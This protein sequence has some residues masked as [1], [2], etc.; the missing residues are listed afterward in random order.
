LPAAERSFACWWKVFCVLA[1][2]WYPPGIVLIHAESLGESAGEGGRE[3]VTLQER[4]R[5]SLVRSGR[6]EYPARPRWIFGAPVLN[7]QRGRAK[8][9]LILAW[10]NWQLPV[11]AGKVKHFFWNGKEKVDFY[12]EHSLSSN[13]KKWCGS[14]VVSK[15]VR[16]FAQLFLDTT[17]IIRYRKDD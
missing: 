14:F 8:F 13:V 1:K 5:D 3:S 7:I 15:K 12:L 9:I 10:W 17:N 4:V 16:T 11:S 6:A 2:G